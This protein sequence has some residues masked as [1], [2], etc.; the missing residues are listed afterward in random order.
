M[1]D[2]L[3]SSTALHSSLPF[4]PS[5]RSQAALCIAQWQN[6]KAP[7]S[8]DVVSTDA[9]LGLDILLQY[10]QERFEDDNGNILPSKFSRKIVRRDESIDYLYADS[11][12]E[13]DEVIEEDYDFEEDEE[14]RV[15]S[16]VITAIACIRAKD[17]QTPTKVL[18]FL[19]KVLLTS[20]IITINNNILSD[21][22]KRQKRPRLGL[23][24]YQEYFADHLI[25]EALLA[26]CYINTQPTDIEPPF[27]ISSSI[28][29]RAYLHPILPLIRVCWRWLKW[30]LHKEKVSFANIHTAVSGVGYSSTNIAPNAI[31][32]LCT[33]SLLYQSTTS[34]KQ[35]EKTF[36]DEFYD[37]TT[38]QFYSKIVD[39][40]DVSDVTRAAAAQAVACIYCASDRLK[41]KND[42][43]TGLLLALTFLL[44]RICKSF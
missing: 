6:N 5:V 32:A 27:S 30:G 15:R 11:L 34:S 18:K 29:E 13:D 40:A 2:C 42:G 17:G 14:Y 12:K 4:T 21:C 3:R 8:I 16:S 31:T 36:L 20:D 41:G 1:G 38:T 26:L 23:L 37:A 22:E 44:D 28:N 10:F 33:M 9:W 43:P 39:D 19:E 24:E 25:G 35:A 7:V